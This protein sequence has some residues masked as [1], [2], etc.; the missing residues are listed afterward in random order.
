MAFGWSWSV[1]HIIWFCIVGIMNT[2]KINTLFDR[3]IEPQRYEIINQTFG[4]ASDVLTVHTANVCCA[5]LVPFMIDIIFEWLH[6]K[7]CN[8]MHIIKYLFVVDNKWFDGKHRTGH[9]QIKFL[10]YKQFS[11]L[12]FSVSRSDL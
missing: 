7:C 3:L 9:C 4:V 6:C 5:I 8:Y 10:V 2:N 11:R 1:P 12:S